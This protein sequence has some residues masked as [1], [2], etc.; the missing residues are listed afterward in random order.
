MPI[1]GERCARIPLIA[2]NDINDIEDN[3]AKICRFVVDF[4]KGDVLFAGN[5]NPTPETKAAASKMTRCIV[6]I[7]QPRSFE[8]HRQTAIGKTAEKGQRENSQI[9]SS[10]SAKSILLLVELR[11]HIDKWRHSPSIEDD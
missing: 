3:I 5:K 1:P 2:N 6:I 4:N 9:V 11:R 8:R 10:E 7:R